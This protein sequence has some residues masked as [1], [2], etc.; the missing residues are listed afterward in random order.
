MKWLDNGTIYGRIS[1]CPFNRPSIN[2]T[3][4]IKIRS[5]LSSFL[6]IFNEIDLRS[7]SEKENIGAKRR[8]T[9]PTASAT[10][11]SHCKK[12]LFKKIGTRKLIRVKS[13]SGKKYSDKNNDSV[14]VQKI[15]SPIVN[16]SAETSK[17]KFRKIGTKKLVRVKSVGLLTTP[18]LTS[19]G[20]Y[21]LRTK[22][23]IIV[24]TPR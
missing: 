9:T 6:Y 2:G 19:P 4:C 10:T 12:S 17:T 22:R 18:P 1:G 5:R 7:S 13:S 16:R 15:N 20:R 24:K 23:K 11:T 8:T 21:K 14:C 3:H